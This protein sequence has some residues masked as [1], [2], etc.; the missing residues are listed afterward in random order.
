VIGA[1]DGQVVAENV[2]RL[3]LELQHGETRMYVLEAQPIIGD[4]RR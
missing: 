3:E 1:L 4:R 2:T